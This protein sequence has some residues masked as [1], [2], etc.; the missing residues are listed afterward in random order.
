MFTGIVEEL[1]TV[2]T[3]E[4][5]DN[6]V[7]VTLRAERVVSGLQPGASIAVSG[8]CQTVLDAE[9][10]R[11]R[12]A[13]E[14]ETLRLT[15]LGSLRPGAAVNLERALRADGRFDGH[16]VLGH[17]DGRGHVTAVRSEG[18]TWVLEVEVPEH[19]RAFVVPKGS[20][21][22]D[23]VSLTVG[24]RVES[25]R[26]ELFLIPYTWDHTALHDLR[27]G[28]AVNVETDILGRYVAHLLGGAAD[29]GGPAI[30]WDKLQRAFGGGPS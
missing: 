28:A 22:I 23:G 14:A 21:A 26:F 1:G 25:G 30:T 29:S 6:G 4:P 27:P 2:A 20:I 9:A 15:T 18:R 10:G 5:R 24:P 19:L 16:I 11:F 12:V 7:V 3:V 8:V 13:A 17:V